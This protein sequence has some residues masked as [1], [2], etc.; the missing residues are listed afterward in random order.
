MRN[1]T[2]R[3][4]KTLIKDYLNNPN[5]T[6]EELG[7]RNGYTSGQAASYQVSKYLKLNR[8]NRKLALKQY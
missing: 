5:Q 6:M 2:N 4:N 3:C 8:K 1:L 7:L